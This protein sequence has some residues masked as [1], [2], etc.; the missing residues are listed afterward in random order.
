M[1][2]IPP[3]GTL[4]SPPVLNPYALSFMPSSGMADVRMPPPV[5]NAWDN[6]K[7][8]RA[9]QGFGNE[10][11]FATGG[12]NTTFAPTTASTVG[13]LAA[14]ALGASSLLN[15][16]M[17]GMGAFGLASSAV[18]GLSNYASSV[19]RDNTN[20]QMRNQDFDAARSM[21]LYH[22]SQIPSSSFNTM[23]GSHSVST[24]RT[25]NQSVYG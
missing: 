11:P 18:G 5:L 8:Y 9:R 25:F 16:S 24:P 20:L 3:P 2:C 12:L 1:A 19:H 23:R 17:L 13:K 21:G 22:P 4:S 14:G 10:V 6:L 15:P 7:N